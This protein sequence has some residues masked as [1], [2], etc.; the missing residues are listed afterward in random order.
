MQAIASGAHVNDVKEWMGHRHLS[1]TM[2]Y[3][4]HRPRDD[5]AA[6]LE[7]HFTGAATQR[8][9]LLGEPETSIS[10]RP[11]RR[12][13]TTLGDANKSRRTATRGHFACAAINHEVRKWRS[14]AISSC[15]RRDSN[16]RHADYD[17][18][19]LTD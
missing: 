18:A 15:R 12:L 16:P 11:I 5:A 2:R 8:E 14:A 17:S 4:H 1:T 13:E 19:A 9:Q 3:V 10:A 6:T 7:R